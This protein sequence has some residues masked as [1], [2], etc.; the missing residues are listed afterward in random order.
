MVVANGDTDLAAIEDAVRKAK[1][2][3]KPTLIKIK[4]TIGFGSKKEGTG[5]VH[6]APLGD[7]DIKNVK[8]KF[9]L[10]PE[11]KF[12]I[13]NDVKESY[14]NLIEKGKL[15]EER[16]ND[17]YNQFEKSNPE[18]AKEFKRRIEGKLP[19][20]WEK[21]LP[22]YEVKDGAIASRNSSAKVLNACCDAIPEIVGGSA[23]LTGSNKTDIKSSHD[24]QA[25][26]QDG[27]YFRFGVREH[28]MSAI[29]NGL[30][31]Y[32]GFIPFGATFLNFAGYMLGGMRLSALSHFQV[33]YILTHDSIGLGED[34]PTHQPVNMLL[35]LRSIPNMY[36]FRPADAKEVTGCYKKSIELRQSPR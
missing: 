14:A 19:T 3:D 34:G 22:K 7:D 30:A 11:K 25:A 16:W 4:T 20:G 36:T 1:L 15:I 12:N 24:Y 10:D 17:L 32:G 28:G 6:G 9:N 26:T 13:E 31:A 29:C 23:D 33:L 5:G 8:K 27:R 2:S 18:K 21:Q 35:S